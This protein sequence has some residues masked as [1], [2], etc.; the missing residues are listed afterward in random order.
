M[1]EIYCITNSE[2]ILVNIQ[3]GWLS[4]IHEDIRWITHFKKVFKTCFE[5]IQHPFYWSTHSIKNSACACL[6]V[7]KRPVHGHTLSLQ[8]LGKYP[9]NLA[10]LYTFGV[11]FCEGVWVPIWIYIW[12]A[13][14][15]LPPDSL[16]SSRNNSPASLQTGFSLWVSRFRVL[17][18][19]RCRRGQCYRVKDLWGLLV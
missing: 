16:L 11:D 2:I 19:Y 17:F 14:I 10:K 18:C 4:P 9:K 12:E 5:V 7:C 6:A 13:P 8:N 15:V 1:A 3:G